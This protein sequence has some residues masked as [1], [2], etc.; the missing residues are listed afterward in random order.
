MKIKSVQPHSVGDPETEDAFNAEK[1]QD[2][3]SRYLEIQRQDL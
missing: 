3:S 2:S 1:Y